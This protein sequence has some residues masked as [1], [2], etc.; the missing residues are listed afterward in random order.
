MHHRAVTIK[1]H[2]PFGEPRP[3]AE[4]RLTR[5]GMSVVVQR[6]TSH[7]SD[8]KENESC[9]CCFSHDPP[10]L[11]MQKNMS[12]AWQAVKSVAQA[13]SASLARSANLLIAVIRSL[14]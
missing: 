7:S 12:G 9:R 2:D 10:P 6:K 11:G 3:F 8:Q 14:T 4:D 13:S 5:G 1:C